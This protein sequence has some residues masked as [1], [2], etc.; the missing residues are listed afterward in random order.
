MNFAL[1]IILGLIVMLS[2]GFGDLFAAKTVRRIGVL[3]TIFWDTTILLVSFLIIF[4]V[5]YKTVDLTSI[6]I[7]IVVVASI[8]GAASFISYE[9]GLQVGSV[10]IVSPVTSVW[11][12][13]TVILSVIFLNLPISPLEAIA[14][15]ML[16]AGSV[17]VSLQL[18]QLGKEKGNKII[19]G[20]KYGILSALGWGCGYFLVNY[21]IIGLNWFLPF[22][23][24]TT[25]YFLIFSSLMAVKKRTFKIQRGMG[26]YVLVLGLLG[27]V[28][29]ASY[30]QGIN[31]GFVLVMAPLSAASPAVS[32]LL[33]FKFLKERLEKTQII[34]V[35][36]IIFGL[37]VLALI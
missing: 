29:M 6:T 13:I 10:A 20:A 22:L 9:K 27:V 14:I 21:L 23:L 1:A 12:G 4:L 34:G 11:S 18:N 35:I 32:V 31:S 37:V 3:R 2:D 16:I 15:I 30:G 8:L 25:I 7:L 17:L 5:F 26:T 19:T 33:A 36:S 28:S 24:Y